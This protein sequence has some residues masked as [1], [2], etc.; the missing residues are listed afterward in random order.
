MHQ[1]LF[2]TLIVLLTKSQAF[3]NSYFPNTFLFPEHWKTGA[4]KR[5]RKAL[6]SW[7]NHSYNSE[8]AKTSGE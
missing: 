4:E 1:I 7:Q 6:T 5:N 8:E 2:T 3:E